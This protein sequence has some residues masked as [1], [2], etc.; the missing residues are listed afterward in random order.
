MLKLKFQYFGH[1]IWRANSL[2]KTL[3]LG[4]IK[5]RRRRGWQRMRWLDGITSQW[6][7][8]WA[9]SGRQWRT[10]KPGMLQATESQRVRHV[11]ATEQHNMEKAVVFKLWYMSESPGTFK[12][13]VATYSLW[14]F[15]SDPFYLNLMIL[16]S[17]Y[18]VAYCCCCSVAKS[19][20]SV[21]TLVFVSE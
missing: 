4:K 3:M 12:I 2:G 11:L 1:M 20:V 21:R 14:H 8:V 16:R 6:T 9:N 17:I 13:P 5:S 10:G 19:V 15:V 18:I 7:W